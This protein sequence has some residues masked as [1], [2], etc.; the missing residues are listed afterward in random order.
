MRRLLLVL[1][2]ALS[3]CAVGLPRLIAR[4]EKRVV[5]ISEVQRDQNN[6]VV[7]KRAR[8]GGVVVSSRGA[9]ITCLHVVYGNRNVMADWLSGTQHLY[10]VGAID[11][12]N[13]LA[14]LIPWDNMGWVPYALVAPGVTKGEAVYHI[15]HPLRQKWLATAGIVSLVERDVIVA[16][17]AA[18]PGS[19]GGGVFNHKGELIGIV[20]RGRSLFIPVFQGHTEATRPDVI[21]RFLRI[22]RNILFEDGPTVE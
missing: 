5:L 7:V 9:I 6:N 20:H 19:S 16:D 12:A 21:E 8:G 15:G 1:C 2:V 3:G 13:D 18:N 4:S 11:A 10:K 22:N 17:A 14:L